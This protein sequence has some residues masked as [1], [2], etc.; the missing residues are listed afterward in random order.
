MTKK[1]KYQLYVKTSMVE[2]EDKSLKVL[3][4]AYVITGIKNKNIE[5]AT[6]FIKGKN[7]HEITTRDVEIPSD[8]QVFDVSGFT[9]MPGLIDA[10]M[11]FSGTRTHKFQERIVVKSEVRL[12]RAVKDAEALLKAGFTT[13][14]D[15]GGINAVYL[16]DAINEGTIQGPRIFAAGYPLSQT[17]GHA[18]PHYFPLHWAKEKIPTICDGV[19]E[20]IKAARIAFREGADFIK[21]MATGGVM[22]QRDSP[23]HEGFT[24]EEI[25]AIVREAE[26]VGSYVSAHA[27]GRKG[28]VK[29]VKAGVRTVA[30]GFEIDDDT[31]QLLIEKNVVYVPTLSIAFQL[32]TKGKDVGVVDWALKKIQKFFDMHVKSAKVA[33]KNGVKFATGTDFGGPPLFKMGT[34]ALELK[35]LVEKIGMSNQEA[36]IAAT[37]N[38]AEACNF[39]RFIGTVSVGKYADLIVV[40]GNPLKDINVLLDT[41][42]VHM[43]FKEGRLEVNKGLN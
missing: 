41:N 8:A 40:K 43:V 28:M 26:K 38:A 12:I 30:H 39:E 13:V 1:P 17:F 35:L 16:R 23:T 21:I 7:I 42:N 9:V 22:S 29:A 20:C 18:D 11:H 2:K 31:A 32:A 15:C 25:K 19:D 14:K 5:D 36:I 37:S 4:G 33:Y 34:N 3:K 27:E 6:I 10:H 24:F